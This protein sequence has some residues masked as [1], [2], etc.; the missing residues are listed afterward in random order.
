MQSYLMWQSTVRP[1]GLYDGH[2]EICNALLVI[3]KLTTSLTN[4]M[5]FRSNFFF[6]SSLS[7]LRFPTPYYP[8]LLL[9]LQR[10]RKH[11]RWLKSQIWRRRLWECVRSQSPVSLSAACLAPLHGRFCALSAVQPGRDMHPPCPVLSSA[12]CSAQM[13][14]QFTAHTKLDHFSGVLC[15]PRTCCFPPSLINA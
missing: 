12:P 13:S 4:S 2:G 10:G 7:S 8:P 11:P 14:T 9:F 3:S 1:E 15:R 6:C 5:N